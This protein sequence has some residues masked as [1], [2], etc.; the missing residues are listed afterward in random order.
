MKNSLA[1][2]GLAALVASTAASA[3]PTSYTADLTHAAVV[4][5]SRH[6]G[7]S[8]TSIKYPVK[9]GT[10]TLDPTAGTAKGS[11][12]IDLTKVDS[13]VP[14]LDEHLKTAQ[15]FNAGTYP[16]AS[17]LITSARYAGDKLTQLSGELSMAGKTN[18]VTLNA[19]NY[20]CYVSPASK[21][22]VCGGD[23]ETTIQ[24]TQWGINYLVPF[25]SDETK[26]QIQIEATKD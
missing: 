14:K 20:N 17:F 3:E 5:Q 19:T 26:L 11:F 25:V 9:S 13:G 23:F 6:F 10:V 24:R 22:S 16:E 12:V 18:P 1:L 21:K 4:S 7:T 8:T 2:L 15:F